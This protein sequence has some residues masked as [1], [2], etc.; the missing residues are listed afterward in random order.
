MR[1]QSQLRASRRVTIDALDVGVVGTIHTGPCSCLPHCC[2]VH[3]LETLRDITYQT[4]AYLMVIYLS[5]TSVV[6][7]QFTWLGSIGFG[8]RIVTVVIPVAIVVSLIPRE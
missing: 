8:L 5:D 3:R 6:R 2:L 7:P 4:S 1:L